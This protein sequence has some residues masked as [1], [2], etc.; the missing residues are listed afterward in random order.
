MRGLFHLM[1]KFLA[2]SHLRVERVPVSQA[3]TA[4]H[5]PMANCIKVINAGAMIEALVVFAFLVFI[6]LF[7]GRRQGESSG[8]GECPT[9]EKQSSDH[10]FTS[11][12]GRV[13]F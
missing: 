1:R 5:V 9:Q 10:D 4:A 11:E 7:L 8:K 13:L 2:H 12:R 3:A 6:F